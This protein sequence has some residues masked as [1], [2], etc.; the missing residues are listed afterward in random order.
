MGQITR[1]ESGSWNDWSLISCP[2]CWMSN[3]GCQLHLYILVNRAEVVFE[4]TGLIS[5]TP[6]WC[7]SDWN[8]STERH[9]VILFATLTTLEIFCRSSLPLVT[10]S[11]TKWY[12]TS[13]C[14]E[15]LL[16][17]RFFNKATTLCH[18]RQLEPNRDRLVEMYMPIYRAIKLISPRWMWLHIRLRSSRWSCT[19]EVLTSTILLHCQI[20][21]STRLLTLGCW[22]SRPSLSRCNRLCLRSWSA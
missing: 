9:L 21:I 20:W 2:K 16:C 14:F 22:D 12:W 4:S 13:I 19:L 10:Q 18:C 5:L 15:A 17:T 7:L 8:R 1:A 11:R 3:V 6:I